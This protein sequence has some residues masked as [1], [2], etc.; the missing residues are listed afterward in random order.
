MTHSVLMI[1]TSHE[2]L[3][4]TGSRTG[5]WLEE[6][7]APYYT[8]LDAGLQVDFTSIAGGAAPIDP[9]SREDA[10]VTAAGKRFLA[11]PQAMQKLRQTQ[12]ISA[13][14]GEGYRAL[15]LVGGSGT[16]W[17]FPQNADVKRLVEDLH[18]RGKIVAG[19]CHGV[20]GL[21]DAVGPDGLTLLKG[22]KA[23][24]ISNREDELAGVAPIVPVLPE[25]RLKKAG[26]IYIAAAPFEAHV[27]SDGSVFT[28]QNP[29]SARP[30]AEAIVLRL[31]GHSPSA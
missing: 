27:V 8:F 17:D 1:L 3:G 19:V 2:Q 18:A 12:P 5:S 21:A 7:A 29:A 31:S 22:R 13:M 4:N 6:L 20:L 11:D 26:A 24:G 25:E 28:G 30:L 14:Q 16:A 10:W 23:T 15:F 9:M